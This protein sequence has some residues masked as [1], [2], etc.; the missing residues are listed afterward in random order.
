MLASG[1]DDRSLTLWELPDGRARRVPRAQPARIHSVA[2]SPDGQTI[3]SGIE[4]GT[5]ALWKVET[6]QLQRVFKGPVGPSRSLA[7]SPDGQT[8]AA[9]TGDQTI[10]LY[11]LATGQVQRTLTRSSGSVRSL[12]FS[13]DGQTL[14][15]GADD[16][17]IT[18]WHVASGRG[19]R[20]LKGNAGPVWSLVFSPDGQTLAASAEDRT[21]RL[22]SRSTA[23]A[24]LTLRSQSIVHGLAYRHDGSAL[25]AGAEDG[26]LTV[27]DTTRGKVL[28]SLSG[29]GSQRVSVAFSADLRWLVSVGRDGTIHIADAGSGTSHAV[30]I[31]LADGWVAFT[32]DG[33]Y[34]LKGCVD[35]VF[36]HAI[37]LYRFEPGELDP[38]LP[39]SLR[40][41][42]D[43]PILNRI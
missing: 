10:T 36:W 9:A 17:A 20:V 11:T 7:F 5:I 41:P 22:F 33:R 26:S 30:L 32:P 31:K 6:G 4:D 38:H 16:P 8:L 14:A 43:A 39:A 3:A 42:E 25:Y 34:K 24:R 29:Q 1:G 37:G 27:W 35:G 12:V 13:P 2:L 15:A 19:Q 21:V 40:L 23:D 18:L 28:Q